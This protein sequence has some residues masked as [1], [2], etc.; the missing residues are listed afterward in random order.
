MSRSEITRGGK[1]VRPTFNFVAHGGSTPT[2]S[3]TAQMLE[4]IRNLEECWFS[5][6][7]LYTARTARA[8]ERIDRRLAKRSPL[9]G[10]RHA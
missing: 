3:C 2:D 5:E 9:K 10:S 7:A 1:K 8:L 6:I 4:S